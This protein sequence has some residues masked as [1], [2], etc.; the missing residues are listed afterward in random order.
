MLQAALRVAATQNGVAVIER[1]RTDGWGRV[2]KEPRYSAPLTPKST[3]L[4]GGEG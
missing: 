1:L 2:G 3:A 4:A